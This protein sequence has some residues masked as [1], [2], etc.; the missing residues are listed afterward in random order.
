MSLIGRNARITIEGS[1]G[2]FLDITDHI[3]CRCTADEVP[4]EICG[5]CGQL[6][7]GSFNAH[8]C[9]PKPRVVNFQLPSGICQRCRDAVADNALHCGH[10]HCC[11]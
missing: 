3:N 5:K 2:K 4:E 11:K 7:T 10:C 1:D 6:V 8:K 9:T